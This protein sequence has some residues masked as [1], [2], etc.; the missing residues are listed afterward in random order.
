MWLPLVIVVAVLIIV[1]IYT[2][3]RT[4][5]RQM[6]RMLERHTSEIRRLRH[7]IDTKRD[8]PTERE[9]FPSRRY[10]HGDTG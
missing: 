10:P 7:I 8:T 9:R 5:R 2:D 4:E 3:T 1:A 6:R